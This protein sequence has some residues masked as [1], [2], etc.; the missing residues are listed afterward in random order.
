MEANG[1]LRFADLDR[2]VE[3]VEEALLAKHG[4]ATPAGDGRAS[5]EDTLLGIVPERSCIAALLG[6]MQRRELAAGD[7]LLRQGDASDALILMESGQLTA[8]LERPGQRPLRL[9]TM[10]GAN[11]LGELGFF[12]G[13]ARSAS[14]V[15]DTA[16]VVHCLDQAG[17]SALRLQHPDLAGALDR[18]VIHQ[19]SLRVVHLTKV[20]DALG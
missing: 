7:M 6:K 10:H 5:L 11:I 8:L 1:L 18:L 17:F 15:A 3:W 4:L 9:Q 16:T 14:V 12:L 19:L 13:S 2:G 20:V